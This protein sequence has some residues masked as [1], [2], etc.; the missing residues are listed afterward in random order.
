[1]LFGVGSSKDDVLEESATGFKIG[2]GANLNENIAVEA[3]FV[4]L[5]TIDFP[6]GVEVSQYGLAGSLKPFY[7]VNDQ[8]AIFARFGLYSWTFE[9]T[10]GFITLE[11]TGVDPFIGFGVEFKA[12]DKAA[13][14]A[15]YEAYDVSDGD[16]SLLSIGIKISF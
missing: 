3:A 14:I 12:G 8:A 4:D 7:N 16:V 2:I 6:F 10:D 15:E 9:I 5:G 11:D 13:V 1:M